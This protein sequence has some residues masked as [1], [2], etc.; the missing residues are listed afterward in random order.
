MSSVRAEQLESHLARQLGPLYAIHGDEPLLALEAADAIRARARKAGFTERSVLVAERGFKWGELGAAGASLSLFG[1]RKLIELRIASGKPGPDGA[2]AIEAYCNAL[3]PDTLLV[4]SLPRLAKRDQAASWFAALSRAGVVVD[5]WPVERARLPE[6]I[7]GRLAR[8]KQRADKETLAFL[9]DSVEGN[10]LAAH[11]EIQKLA[12]LL[13]EGALPFD[14][15]RAA[16]LNVARYDAGQ[17]SEAVLSGDPARLVRMLEGLRAEGEAPPRIVWILAEEIRAIARIQ[18]GLA[19][20]RPL[21]ELCRENRI[22]G[23]P[24]QTLV[25]RAARQVSRNALLEALSHAARIDRIA[26]GVAMG[27]AWDELLQLGLRF[28]S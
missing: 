15:V 26:K 5:V 6:W 27:D 13:P 20:G 3:P 25:G 2:Q 10:L 16:V 18:E 19:A 1:D 28:A 4:V 8:Q 24:R 7:A 14:E 21:A 22:W 9:A 12:M 23:E 17:L 11:Q